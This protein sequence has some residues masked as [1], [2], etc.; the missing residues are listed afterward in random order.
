VQEVEA[1][2]I[3]TVTA[4]APPPQQ[5]Q[6]AV[7]APVAPKDVQP[8]EVVV[9]RNEQQSFGFSV[10]GGIEDD[11]LPNI[12]LRPGV[13]PL[14]VSGGPLQNDDEIIAINGTNVAGI[15]H[16]VVI[17]LIISS[18]AELKL[19]VI[20]RPAAVSRR[21]SDLLVAEKSGL[22]ESLIKTI[23]PDVQKSIYAQTVPLTSR[24]PKTGQFLCIMR[25][26]CF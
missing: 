5:A 11:L 21:I 4:Q 8:R 17:G 12:K 14:V 9:R 13:T 18:P 1:K 6:V 24:P 20:S 25:Y 16:E 26:Y 2:P 23:R 15:P 7:P 3:S 19:T 22:P 10:A